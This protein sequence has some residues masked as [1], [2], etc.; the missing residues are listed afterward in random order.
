MS[1]PEYS[2][3]HIRVLELDEAVRSRPGMYFGLGRGNPDLPTRVLAAVLAHALHP[4]TKL[5]PT[6]S[7]SV[8]AEVFDDL[9]FSVTDDQASP[10]DGGTPQPGVFGSLLGTDRWLWAAAAAVS[11]CAV[12]EVWREGRGFRRTLAAL[13]PS[14]PREVFD[15]PPGRG[16]KVTFHLCPSYFGEAAAISRDLTD[17][18]LH[19][20]DCAVPPGPGW[21]TLLDLRRGPESS[22]IEYT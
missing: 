4:A 7:P 6:H 20:R 11:S 9:A 22:P 1:D 15:A 10:F 12:V 5:A 17:L 14:G 8:Y 13:R 2:S 19:G 3:A 21:V 18:D 16:T